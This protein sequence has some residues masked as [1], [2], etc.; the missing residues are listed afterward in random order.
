MPH[1]SRAYIIRY[2]DVSIVILNYND[3]ERTAGL[4]RKVKTQAVFDHIIIVDNASSDDSVEHLTPLKD[5]V[6]DLIC[7]E[8]NGG[9]AAGN[10]FGVLHALKSYASDIIFIANPDVSFEE[11]TALRMVKALKENP[12]I[13]IIA[14]LVS[15]GCNAW[16]LPG[17]AGVIRSL[18]L[19][20]FTLHKK[21]VRSRIESCAHNPVRTGVVEG[22]FFAMPAAAYK[23]ARGFDER[24]FL[25]SE[26]IIMARRIGKAG[27]TEAVLNDCFYDHLH[28][29]SIKKLYHS[30]KAGAFHHFRDSFRVYN[31]YYLHTA[32]WEDKIFDIAYSL[33]LLE[34]HLYDRIHKMIP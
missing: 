9:Y 16:D 15:S 11:E 32:P 4:V 2:M 24:T 26:E 18:F 13:G 31:R 30:S 34:R 27:Y 5:S 12:S 28:S 29:A 17:F 3:A 10:N 6:T 23:A 1:L 33:A 22:S 25:Y 7:A 21:K 20:A 14:P 19:V 8:K